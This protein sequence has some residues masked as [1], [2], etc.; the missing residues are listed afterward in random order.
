MATNRVSTRSGKPAFLTPPMSC[1]RKTALCS[2]AYGNLITNP[3]GDVGCSTLDRRSTHQVATKNVIRQDESR[4]TG[5][6][7]RCWLNNACSYAFVGNECDVEISLH[8]LSQE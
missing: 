4:G 7:P 1:H 8:V 6:A 5:G 3:H 2:E